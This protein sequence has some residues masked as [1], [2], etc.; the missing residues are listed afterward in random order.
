M[1]DRKGWIKEAYGRGE[2]DVGI[3]GQKINRCVCAELGKAGGQNT[4]L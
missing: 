4:V 2:V 3:K 1:K